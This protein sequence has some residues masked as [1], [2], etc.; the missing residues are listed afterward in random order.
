M[1]CGCVFQMYSKVNQ[2]CIHIYSLFFRFISGRR[3]IKWLAGPRKEALMRL[4]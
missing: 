2:L 4:I 3:L 1:F